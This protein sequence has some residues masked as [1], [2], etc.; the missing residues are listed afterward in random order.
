MKNQNG[1]EVGQIWQDWDK[2]FRHQTPTYKR[3][4]KVDKK[5]AYCVGVESGRETRIRLDRFKPNSTG[6]RLTERRVLEMSKAKMKKAEAIRVLEGMLIVKQ[7]SLK[8]YKKYGGIALFQEK[9][10]E[11]LIYALKKLKEEK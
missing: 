11:A 9:D 4:L 1:V 3:V 6:Y 5:F 10:V 7:R 8:N 2:R